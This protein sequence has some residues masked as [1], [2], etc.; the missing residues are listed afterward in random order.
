MKKK[1]IEN[2]QD[3]KDNIYRLLN[4]FEEFEEALTDSVLDILKINLS[5]VYETFNCLREDIERIQIPRKLYAKNQEIFKEKMIA[6][7]NSSFISFCTTD[8]IKGIP[9][10]PKL[11]ANIMAILNNKRCIHHSH[12]TGE[13]VGYAHS[14]CNE[15]VRENYYKIPVIERNL[16]RFDFFSLKSV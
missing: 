14:F 4:I 10:S 1:E 11:I 13:I 7:L 12:I 15:Q 2:L 9:V 16:F 3:Y 8:K 6:F 5:D